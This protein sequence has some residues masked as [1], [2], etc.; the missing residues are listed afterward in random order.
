S[1]RG[2]LRRCS[3]MDMLEISIHP[4]LAE[5]DDPAPASRSQAH[6]SIHPLLAERDPESRRW[7]PGQNI[8]IHPLLAERDQRALSLESDIIQFQ[9][10]LSSRRGTVKACGLYEC[11]EVISIHPLLAERDMW[12]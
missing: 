3:I 10:T 8:S 4:L 6:I 9:S 12:P 2:T 1:R 11:L 7:E 5:R